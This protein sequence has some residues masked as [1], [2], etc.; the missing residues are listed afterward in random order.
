[1]KNFIKKAMVILFLLCVS[2]TG[3]A[4]SKDFI[5]KDYDEAKKAESF[6][7]FDMASTKVGLFTTHFNGFVKKFT[8]SGDLKDGKIQ[9]A[10]IFFEAKDMDTDIGGRNEKMWNQ[11]LEVEKYPQI[12][13]KFNE[14][15]TLDAQEKI[16][17][18][19]ISIRGQHHIIELK[20]K[21]NQENNQYVYD[22]SGELSIKDLNIPDPSIAIAS[23]KDKVDISAHLI[24]K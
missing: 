13:I 9:N 12:K 7:R 4:E 1:M 3:F 14:P 20:V 18:A 5:F 8:I 19:T 15:L 6:V 10:A 17:P 23:V 2:A 16:I 22:L 11:C 24:V 21:V